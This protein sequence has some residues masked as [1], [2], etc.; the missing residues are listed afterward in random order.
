[1]CVLCLR[2]Q[3]SQLGAAL[4][5]IV[6]GC[7]IISPPHK[8]A[9]PKDAAPVQ[10]LRMVQGLLNQMPT[11]S[12]KEFE[13]EVVT[14][15]TDVALLNLLCMITKGIES[16]HTLATCTNEAFGRR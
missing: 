13:D 12:S 4:A 7:L 15:R 14:E 10:V 6:P 11:M 1:M 16:C 8:S 9:W 3:N 5:F 2:C